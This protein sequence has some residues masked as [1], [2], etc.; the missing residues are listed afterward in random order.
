MSQ[1]GEPSPRE[2]G[3]ATLVASCLALVSACTAV[4][5]GRVGIADVD[6]VGTKHVDEDDVLAKIATTKTPR[7]LG[8]LR[9]VVHEYEVFDP[10]VLERDRERIERM[11]RAKGY[12]RARVLRTDVDKHGDLV[13]VTFYVEEG[14]PT[15]IREV[16]LSGVSTLPAPLRETVDDQVRRALPRGAPLDEDAFRKL[17]KSLERQL[18]DAGYAYAEVTR[19]AEVNVRTGDVVAE[20]RARPGPLSTF[21]EVQIVGLGE[22]PED[23]IRPLIDIEPG[24]RF[25]TEA[26]EEVKAELVALNLFSVV[27]VE[28]LRGEPGDPVR[29]RVRAEPAN[30]RTIRL[31]GGVRLDTIKSDFHFLAGW[32]DRNFVG[33]MRQFSVDVRPGLVLYPLRIDNWVA[34]TAVLPEGRL[35]ISLRQPG[36][37]EGHT[38]GFVRPGGKVFAVLLKTTVDPDDP[39]IGYAEPSGSIGL[40]RSFWRAL[41]RLSVNGQVDVPFAYQGDLDP[42][43]E[44][45]TITYPEL[46]VTLDLRD[47]PIQP[48]IGAFISASFQAGVLGDAQDVRVR[49]EVRGYLP[50][51]PRV[52][53]A[54][55]TGA[56]MLFPFSYGETFLDQLGSPTPATTAEEVRDLQ[57]VFFRGFFAGGPNSNRGYPPNTISPHGVVPYLSPIA[58]AQAVVTACDVNDP[59]YDPARC[60]IPIGGL[61]LWEASL[62]LRF[63]VADILSVAAFCDAAD[64]AP[65]TLDFRFNH[66]HFSCG[67]GLR[68]LTP[69]GPVRLDVGYRIPGAQ[70]PEGVNPRVEGDPGTILGAPIAISFG[71]GEAY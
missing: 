3:S 38:T 51:H 68:F 49:P 42:S 33:G 45:L 13:D 32:E 60:S 14:P 35:D 52:V 24:D 16:T 61:T 18:T 25:S 12:Y 10:L 65:G 43:L 5:P 29:V 40:E 11:F 47:D 66:P 28:P 26:I 9:G 64:V 71:I 7:F 57:L 55:R 37:I 46:E 19:S 67:G 23:R 53:L 39:V 54:A 2:L 34:P 63:L 8:V 6:V 41:L 4:P 56:G 27:E 21:G 69:V 44:T 22:V 70:F 30:L 50:L 62:E 48:K 20:M 1:L 59:A 31:G 36:F 15:R 58:S 17:E